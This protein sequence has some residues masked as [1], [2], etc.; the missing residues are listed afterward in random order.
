M[1]LDHRALS[2]LCEEIRQFLIGHVAETG[3]H[4]ASNL[5]VVEL[6]VALHRVFD[7]N[8]DRLVFDVGHQSYVHK[9]LTGRR[10]QFSSLRKVD[11]IS[12]FPKPEESDAD[13]FIAGHASNSISVALGMARARTLRRE[14]YHV[15]ALTGDGA[16]TGGL[17]YEALNDAGQSGE[18]LIVILND[19]GMS[20]TRNVGG[21]AR[22]LTQLRTKPGY[23]S[24]KQ[25][26]RKFTLRIPGGKALYRFTHKLKTVLKGAL[27][28]CSMFE[29]MGFHY[30]GP[31]DGHNLE[32]LLAVLDWAKR[33][34][35]PVLIHVST[36]K[37]KGYA[38]AEQD[39]DAYHGVS[40]FDPRLGV[41]ARKAQCFSDVF[42]KTMLSLAETEPRVCAITAAMQSATGL[43]AFADAFPARF[44]DVG[45][46]EGHAA[47]MA[48]G[49]AKQGLIPVFAV[50]SSFM[51]RS[52]DMLIHDI[53]LQNLHVVLA[54]DR[55]GLVGED[56]ETH[57]GVF[58]AA[59]LCHIPNLT[60]LCPA[61]F[62]EL[63]AMLEHAVLHVKGPVAVRY[64]RGGERGY[65]ENSGLDP[66][67]ILRR[68]DAVTL[69]GYGIL[70]DTI[71][72]AARQLEE[73][74]IQA[75]VVKLNSIKP[76]DY[77]MIQASAEKTGRLLVAEDAV[78]EGSVGQ[79]ILAELVQRNAAL[80]R[81]EF[82][83]LGDD[84]IPQ[85][86]VEELEARCGIDAAHIVR[87]V[88][89]MLPAEDRACR[90]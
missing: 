12:G 71:L 35:E 20:I 26:Y 24:L 6:T 64:P 8:Q 77:E 40:K 44:F 9:L 69:A 30:L 83:A 46:A 39:P 53:A 62:S 43:S 2:G 67:C 80:K 1:K 23:F 60:V 28:H 58:D 82:C 32:Q 85:G 65:H 42:G 38:Y 54:V 48:G 79:R 19:N 86:G 74:G 45:I 76:I 78:R 49:M 27:F 47:A 11:G 57:Q 41:A 59:Y 73:L 34:P 31:V 18:P 66:A 10:A 15:L 90:R 50:Y 68:G 25:A 36:K 5:G 89:A 3:G 37:G 7:L 13:A 88:C 61:S 29:E 84:F 70:I 22:H 52:Y 63:T 4:L 14:A 56:G 17:S 75:E 87:R 16:L 51:Q 55:A 72:Q 33:L 81:A 21:M